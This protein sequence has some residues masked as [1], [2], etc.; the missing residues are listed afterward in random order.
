MV[1]VL[2][3][4]GARRCS[5]APCNVNKLDTDQ[6]RD[7]GTDCSSR[8]GQSEN[9]IANSAKRSG[10]IREMQGTMYSLKPEPEDPSMTTFRAVRNAVTAVAL[11]SGVASAQSGLLSNAATVTINATKPASLTIAI[12]SGG[13]Q[14]LAA[15]ADNALNNFATPVNITTAWDVNPSAA[16]VVL[17]GYFATP[18]QALANGSDFIASSLVKG[19]LGAA[20]AFNAFTN[21]VVNGGASSVGVAGGSLSLFSQNINGAN[22]TS[23]RT[24]D[25][26]LQIDLVGQP[27]VTAG[28]YT[29]TLNLRAITQ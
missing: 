2:G 5:C 9:A 20:G 23:S 10:T 28:T 3:S 8:H 7:S 27:S 16:A 29:G 6:L 4:P 13:T 19:R 24:D 18:A 12:N 1:A 17:V 14:T 25:L 26:F 11:F 21:G 15:L 22:K